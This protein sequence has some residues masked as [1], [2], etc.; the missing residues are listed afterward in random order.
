MVSAGRFTLLFLPRQFLLVAFTTCFALPMICSADLATSAFDTGRTEGVAGSGTFGGGMV[1]GTSNTGCSFSGTVSSHGFT[2]TLY[3]DA[4][5]A[6]AYGGRVFADINAYGVTSGDP[7][8]LPVLGGG[9]TATFVDTLTVSG[10]SGTGY[11]SYFLDGSIT[12]LTQ[13]GTNGFMFQQGT[14]A[15]EGITCVGP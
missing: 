1:F 14:S 8:W 2:D 4:S 6:A 15:P 11:I 9:A 7:L 3:G 12:S 5:A 10:G 13:I